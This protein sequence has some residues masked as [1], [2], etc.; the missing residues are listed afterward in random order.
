VLVSAALIT[1]LVCLAMMRPPRLENGAEAIGIAL[2][3]V[4]PFAAANVVVTMRWGRYR[5]R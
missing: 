5:K 1:V 4:L 3:A 2:L